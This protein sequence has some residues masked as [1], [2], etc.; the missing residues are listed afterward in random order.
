MEVTIHGEMNWEEAEAHL[1]SLL[2]KAPPKK[3]SKKELQD[4]SFNREPIEELHKDI[5][6]PIYEE[7]RGKYTKEEILFAMLESAFSVSM[8]VTDGDRLETLRLF[9]KA[10]DITRQ[11]LCEHWDTGEE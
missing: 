11:N 7:I 6:V 9:E 10:C 8:S 5:Y 3:L 1:N 4:I 2:E